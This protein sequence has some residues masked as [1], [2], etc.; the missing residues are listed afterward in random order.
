[1]VQT[2][3]YTINKLAKLAGVSVRTLHHYD[4]IGLL[5][6]QRLVSNGY[7]VY[8][9][10]E[11]LQLQQILFFRELGLSLSTIQEI[12]HNPT[13]DRQAALQQQATWIAEEHD[14]LGQLLQ[15]ITKTFR[16]KPMTYTELYEGLSKETLEEYEKEAKERWGNTDAYK[17]SQ[18]RWGSLSP[19]QQAQLLEDGKAAQRKMVELMSEG[20]E[21]PAI[22]AM[23]DDQ[24]R[25][26]N[27]QFYDCSLEMF[28]ALAEMSV[29]DER[30]ATYYRKFHPELPEFHLKAV[31][32]YC[33]Q[34]A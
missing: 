3:E 11:L 13:F 10:E 14:R 16:N 28:L 19:E 8:G 26:I 33:E 20:P 34:H 1:M 4:Q 15:T 21:S 29:S 5:S 31:Q 2:M 17:Q 23:I 32:I 18:E 7:R 12:M 24:Y 27:E 25:G 22:Q 9:Q 30:Y 6:P